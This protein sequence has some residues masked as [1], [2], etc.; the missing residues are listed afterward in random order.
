MLSVKLVYDFDMLDNRVDIL[1][2]H[3]KVWVMEK[4]SSEWYVLVTATE[5]VYVPEHKQLKIINHPIRN[6]AKLS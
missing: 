4:V 1:Y 6:E 5:L 3:D 2:N